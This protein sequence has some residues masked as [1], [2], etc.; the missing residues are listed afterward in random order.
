MRPDPVTRALF[1]SMD[2]LLRDHLYR[3]IEFLA[4][5]G[6]HAKAIAGAVGVSVS[7][8]YLACGHLKI[9]LRDYRDGR[10]PVGSK[11]VA[12]VKRRRLS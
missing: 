11:L 8:V 5:R 10:G 12:R 6:L 3:M 1:R 9:R 7:Q 4:V 2:K